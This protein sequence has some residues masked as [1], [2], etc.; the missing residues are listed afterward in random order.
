MGAALSK[1]YSTWG[2]STQVKRFARLLE[3]CVLVALYV[4]F[5]PLLHQTFG[6]I[7]VSFSWC[8]IGLA[9]WFWGLRGAVLAALFGYFL[10]ITLLKSISAVSM[11][12]PLSAVMSVTVAA[13]LGRLRD[14]SLRLR[15]E[16]SERKNAEKALRKSQDALE[17]RVAER[18]ADLETANK[19][20]RNEIT[21]RKRSEE[22]L[23]ESEE[24]Y[25]SMMEAMKDPVYICSPDFRVEYMNP[26]MIRRTGHDATGEHCFK[27]LHDLKEKCSWC[28]H[29]KAQQGEYFEQNIVSPKGDRSYHVSHSPIVYETGSIS[30]MTV[31]RDITDLKTLEAQFRQ[32]QK[33]EAV[34]RLAGGVAHDFNNLLTTIVGNADLMLMGLAEDNPFREKLEQIKGGGKRAASLTRQL[35]A[36]S[37]KQILQPVVLDLNSLITDFVKMLKRLIGEDVELETV[38]AQELRRVEAD[39]GQMEQVIMN[40]VINAR[41]AMPDGGGLIIET[42]NADLDEDYTKEHD[43][44]LQPGPYV[45]LGVSDTGMGMDAETQSLIFEPFFTTKEE[46][47]GTGLG[48]ATV[49]GIVKQSGGYIWIYSEPG[50]G[51]TFKIYLPAVEGEP[52]QVQKEQTSA[53]FTGSETILIVEDDDVLRNLARKI[54]EL[55]GYKILDA[56]NGIEAL[57]VSDEH[58]G[59]IHLMITDVVMPKMGGRELEE[60]LRPL[61]PEMKVIYTSGYTDDIIAHHGV[62][63]PGIEFLRK[64]LR[65]ESLKR[66]VREV[67]NS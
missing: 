16:L 60:R 39:P 56:E 19:Q 23:R 61:R 18:T 12:G 67:L 20:L 25:R 55:Q 54:L 48:L 36:F 17:Q 15:E 29:Y 4:I 24:K 47:K 50:Q 11:G 30:K 33:M 35:L 14:L 45:M 44:S 65:S 42:V 1:L 49:Y 13:F 58:E 9:V 8:F 3:F 2:K 63:K 62:L 7:S 66:K 6:W 21:E 38:L 10:N 57:R 46:G 34:G 43:V 53:D 40:L 5:F 32:A 52:V 22:A 28:M 64:P 37:R 26:A 31:F 41:D 51:T 59:Q 27:A